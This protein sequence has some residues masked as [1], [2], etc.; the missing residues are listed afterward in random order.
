LL[1]VLIL[2]E[3]YNEEQGR[4]SGESISNQ[5]QVRFP[6]LVLYVDIICRWI[7]S[8]GP[9]VSLPLKISFSKL[10]LKLDMV[11]PISKVRDTKVSLNPFS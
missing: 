9:P 8:Q 11:S 3:G 1:R 2:A 7:F 10:I 4:R 6:D 5:V